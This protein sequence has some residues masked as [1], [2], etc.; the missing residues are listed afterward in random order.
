MS[1][2]NWKQTDPDPCPEGREPEDDLHE[3]SSDCDCDACRDAACERCEAAP[4]CGDAD[5]PMYCQ[6]CADRMAGLEGRL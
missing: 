3:F 2:D 4:M 5:Y 1:W 6:R